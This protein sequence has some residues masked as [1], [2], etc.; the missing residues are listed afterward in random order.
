MPN[1][2]LGVPGSTSHATIS[3]PSPRANA[4]SPS[5]WDSR[6]SG[7]LMRSAP[8]AAAADL[9]SALTFRYQRFANAWDERS[10]R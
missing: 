4:A 7:R 9:I 8:H 6:G 5:E 1:P 3:R 2:D 10:G